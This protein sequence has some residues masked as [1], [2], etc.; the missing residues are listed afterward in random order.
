[1]MTATLG[2]RGNFTIPNEIRQALGLVAGSILVIEVS[3][4]EIVIKPA[5]AQP[6]EKYTMERKA[7]FLLNSAVDLED[8]EEVV[9]TVRAMGF[10]PQKIPH[11]RPEA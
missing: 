10:D 5:I 11:D 6:I 1:M 4:G 3:E 8:Y 7:E 2:Q 9:R